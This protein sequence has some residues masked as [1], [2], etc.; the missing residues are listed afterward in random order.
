[1]TIEAEKKAIEATLDVY[2]SRLDTIPDEQF[3]VSPSGG[4]WSYAEVYSHILQANLGSTIAAE[5]CT[6]STCKPGAKG[7][8]IIGFFVLT[9]K[10]FPP[11]RVKMPK[12]LAAASPVKKIS[13]EEARNLLVKCRRRINEVAA[14]IPKSSARCRIKH[15]RLG[16]LN[17]RQWFRF[18][19]IHSKHHLKQLDRIEKGLK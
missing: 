3:D 16:M 6:L 9:F 17:A 11:F 15:P 5:K 4:G 18:I 12:T 7:C 14:L 8:S 1:M 2:R 13:K 10:R 19:L